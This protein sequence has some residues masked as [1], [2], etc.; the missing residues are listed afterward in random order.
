MRPAAPPRCARPRAFEFRYQYLAGGVN[1]GNGWA[2]WNTDGQFVTL[3]HRGLGRTTASIAGLPVL[4]APPVEPGDR[5]R[6]DGE[7][8]VQ[9]REHR[10]DGRLVRRPAPVLPARGRRHSRSCS[11]SSPTCGATSSRRLDRRRRHDRPG[12]PSRAPATRPWP[13]CRTT[14]PG[15]PAR[16][17]ACATSSR[18]TCCSRTTSRS[19]ARSGT[20]PYRTAR[21]RRS[22][23]S[24]ARAADFYGRSGADFDLDLHRHRRPRRGVQADRLR[25]R[26]RLTLG[27]CRLRPLCPVH[28]GLRGGDRPPRRRVADPARQH[29][30]ARPEQHVGP[31]PG[32]PR[33]V[34]PRGPG[35]DAPR[36][37]ARRRRRRPAVRRRCRRHDLRLRRAGRRRHQPG[38]D[39]RQ[40]PHRRLSADDDGGY[41]RERAAGPTT[42]RAA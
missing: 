20:S 24:P 7:G 2:T 34:V 29:E 35:R 22:T 5:R 27:W 18:P 4:H 21:T 10:D 36:P 32:Q 39:Q 11:T 30:D 3:V 15:S 1:T 23:S 6:R 16:S 28:Q 41:F 42:P 40:H 37:V 38:G 14:P 13:A 26:R 33:R 8:P 19:G 12:R 17:S 9:P 31:L 25:R